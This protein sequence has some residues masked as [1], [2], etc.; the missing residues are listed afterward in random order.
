MNTGTKAVRSIKI[1]CSRR[2]FG[3]N[4]ATKINY[5]LEGSVFIGGAAIQVLR[6]GL[7]LFKDPKKTEKI[8]K[9]AYEDNDGSIS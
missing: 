6:D 8:A 2:R 7:E 9:P 5:A 1:N 3:K 4:L